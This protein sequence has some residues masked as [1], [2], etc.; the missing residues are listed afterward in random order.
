MERKTEI[1]QIVGFQN[2]GKTTLV[3]EIIRY[4]DKLG[5][6]SGTI[7]HHGHGGTPSKENKEKDSEKHLNAGAVY[8]AVEGNGE[9]VIKKQ[10]QYWSLDEIIDY[11]HRLSLDLILIEGYKYAPISK[12]VIIRNQNDLYLLKE[13]T[14]IQ[15][16]LSWIP[17][18]ETVPFPVFSIEEKSRFIAWFFP[19]LFPQHHFSSS[20]FFRKK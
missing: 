6:K 7:K 8:A 3:Q 2:S 9:L 20:E 10:T 19:F 11:Y 13:L 4:G 18:K 12:A 17:L 14:N 5:L 1:F 15:V 16:V